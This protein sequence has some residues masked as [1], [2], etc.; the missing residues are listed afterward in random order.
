LK[1]LIIGIGVIS[2][3]ALVSFNFFEDN[4]DFNTQIRPILNSK[5]MTCH[6]GVR[7]EAGL[8]FLHRESALKELESGNHAIVP[9]SASKSQVIELIQ[10]DNPDLMMPPTGDALTDKEIK[11]MKRWI[12]QGAKWE[13][14]WAYKAIN[15]KLTQSTIKSDWISNPIDQYVLTVLR[16]KGLNHSPIANKSTLLRR[17]SFDLIGLPPDDKLM[18]DYFEDST[19]HAY[20]NLVDSLLQSPHFGERWASMWLDLARYA[21]SS[22]MRSTMICHL[23]SLPL[24]SWPEIYWISP[25]IRIIW[26]R[27]FIEIQ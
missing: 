14:H 22:L 16:D 24:N 15:P 25:L 17:V 2:I 3:L 20:E 6:G 1:K 5:C 27:P 18:Q 10:S 4:V 11:L 9:G 7:Q 13:D 12:N 19:V 8:S 26:L 23:M 21:D